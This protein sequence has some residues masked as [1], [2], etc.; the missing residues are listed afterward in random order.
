M[1]LIEPIYG[2]RYRVI[3]P[4]VKDT[5]NWVRLYEC[6]AVQMSD[7]MQCKCGNTWDV[8]DPNQPI[9]KREEK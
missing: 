8:N 2:K 5:D 6:D 7:K 4:F 1:M 3:E 9:C